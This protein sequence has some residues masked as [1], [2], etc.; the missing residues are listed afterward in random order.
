MKKNFIKL[1]SGS[2]IL[3][4]ALVA[5]AKSHSAADVMWYITRV[6][7][8]PLPLYIAIPVRVALL[9]L[10]GYNLIS[11]LKSLCPK[12]WSKILKADNITTKQNSLLG[13]KKTA[14]VK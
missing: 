4:E 9:T 6:F 2:V 8:I 3:L 5:Y 7:G 11:S 10:G 14:Y 13:C 1:S 12:L